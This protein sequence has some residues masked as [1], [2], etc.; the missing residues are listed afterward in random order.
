MRERELNDHLA[1]ITRTGTPVEKA[2]ARAWV[3]SEFARGHGLDR[4]AIVALLRGNSL[5]P[6][7]RGKRLRKVAKGF[8]KGL[9]R[10]RRTGKR[11]G[12][13][14]TDIDTVFEEVA[15]RHTGWIK[16]FAWVRDTVQ[17]AKRDGLDVSA[18]LNTLYRATPRRDTKKLRRR[19]AEKMRLVVRLRVELD[20]I[21][22][23]GSE[24]VGNGGVGTIIDA[25]I[26]RL[27]NPPTRTGRR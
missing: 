20:R 6:R 25:R 3:G 27:E 12:L 11:E 22:E 15:S 23:V 8:A 9:A 1:R 26:W 13:D 19:S 14:D 4:T 5:D 2:T 17:A 21:K 7:K 16:V 10:T 24:L 18:I